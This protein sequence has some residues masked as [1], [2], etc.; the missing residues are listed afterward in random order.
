M[1]KLPSILFQCW[2]GRCKSY[3]LNLSVNKI[4]KLIVVLKKFSGRKEG[5]VVFYLCLLNRAVICLTG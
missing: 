4:I 5:L 1:L 2:D 3:L